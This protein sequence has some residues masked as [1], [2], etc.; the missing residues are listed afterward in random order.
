MGL[1]TKRNYNPLLREFG[2]I[3]SLLDDFFRDP[4]GSSLTRSP[5]GSSRFAN[6][7]RYPIRSQRVE[8]GTIKV[9]FDV[10]GADKDNIEIHYDEE[11]S[12][13]SVSSKMEEKSEKGNASSSRVFNYQLTVYDLDSDTIEATC[14]KGILTII[15]KP[16]EKQLSR[17]RIEIT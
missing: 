8:D 7:A 1:L 14:D 17:K 11:S 2:E 10:P 9:E 5:W 3:D 6:V 16:I 13:L 15:G 4:W 12:I